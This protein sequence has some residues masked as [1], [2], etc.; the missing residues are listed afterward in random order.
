MKTRNGQSA[1]TVKIVKELYRIRKI[2]VV[3]QCNSLGIKLHHTK[4]GTLAKWQNRK[5]ERKRKKKSN[6]SKLHECR[7]TDKTF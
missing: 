1:M 6:K 7:S 2:A 4:Q 5:G 3:T